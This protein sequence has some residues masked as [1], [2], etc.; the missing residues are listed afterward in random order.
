MEGCDIYFGVKRER[1]REREREI[2]TLPIFTVKKVER[3][4]HGENFIQNIVKDIETR[5]SGFDI[6]SSVVQWW[7][8]MS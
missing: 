2:E 8:K 4:F 3:P 6:R 1:E 7:I 5:Y